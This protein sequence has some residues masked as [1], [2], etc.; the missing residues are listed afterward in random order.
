MDGQ[1]WWDNDIRLIRFVI[2]CFRHCHALRFATPP[3]KTTLFNNRLVRRRVVMLCAYGAIFG[4]R[5]SRRFCAVLSTRGNWYSHQI[6]IEAGIRKNVHEFLSVMRNPV[7]RR[8]CKLI[9]LFAIWVLASNWMDRKRLVQRYMISDS[10]RFTSVSC[11]WLALCHKLSFH[12]IFIITIHRKSWFRS[13]N[14][15]HPNFLLAVSYL[16]Q[17]Q[18]VQPLCRN[19]GASSWAKSRL[20]LIIV[21]KN[22]KDNHRRLS[23]PRHL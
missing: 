6:D 9:S 4:R 21:H 11:S 7:C 16:D 17:L 12:R 2:Q 19:W 23:A 13:F 18:M 3:M 1:S 20:Y 8:Q 14:I 22:E 15:S 5:C 10:F